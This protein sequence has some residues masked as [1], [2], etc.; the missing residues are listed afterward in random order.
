MAYLVWKALQDSNVTQCS[1]TLS[2][3]KS[4][5][6]KFWL[7][8]NLLVS[9][10]KEDSVLTEPTSI[11]WAKG[12]PLSWDVIVPGIFSDPHINSTSAEADT[13]A[14]YAATFKES[15]YVDS[16]ST[17][18]LYPVAIE[19]AGPHDVRARELIEEI[20]RRMTAVAEDTNESNYL[21]QKIS[22]TIQRGNAISFLHIFSNDDELATIAVI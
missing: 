19:T 21:Y 12:K 1:A 10:L 14:K 4:K 11:P 20:G 17:H 2:G 22:I 3:G 13:A 18:L 5:E 8:K 9:P 6:C 16:A 15:N 7:I